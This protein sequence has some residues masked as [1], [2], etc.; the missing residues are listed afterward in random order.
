MEFLI[1]G[2]FLALILHGIKRLLNPMKEKKYRSSVTN[3]INDLVKN[4]RRKI[5]CLDQETTGLDLT[6][7]EIVQLSIID[8]NG[9]VLF[10]EYFKPLHRRSWRDAEAV[11]GISP[12]M[13]K[14]KLPITYHLG[15][16]TRIIE[17]S[18]LIVGYNFNGFDVEI[19]RRAGIIPNAKYVV[20][21]M[22]NFSPIY[23]D[24]NPKYKN[25]TYKKLEVCAKYYKYP[26]Y[27][28]HDSLQ[29]AKATLYCFYEMEK[30][31]QIKIINS[32]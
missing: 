1:L 12:E 11:H 15:E 10:N 7:D 2:L 29:D 28:A 18:S 17:E 14:D 32:I 31:K 9:K 23:G 25:F 4:S 5:I 21:V 22:Q 19:L 27:K 24:W 30:R 3:Q 8:G 26:P 16:I 20:D 6:R 13:V